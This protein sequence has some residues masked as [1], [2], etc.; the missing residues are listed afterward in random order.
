M[1]RIYA[2][3]IRRLATVVAI[4]FGGALFGFA[5]AQSSP[6][7]KPRTPEAAAIKKILEQRFDG[8][9]IGNISKTPYFGLYEVQF[10]D[11]LVYTDAKVTYI[12]VGSIYDAATKKNLTEAKQREYSRISFDSLPLDLAFKRVKGNGA[13]KLAIFSDPDCPYCA[14]LEQELKGIDNVTIYTFL[15]PIDQLHPDAGRKAKVI[16]CSLDPVKAWDQFFDS[17]VLPKN[18]GDCDNPVA[19]TRELGQKLRV[20]ATPTLV[21]ADGTIIPG[22]LPVPQLEAEIVQGEAEAKRLATKK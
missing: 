12:V 5:F 14:R 10:D 21:F 22:A 4:A 18:N 3:A 17:R 9:T 13:R 6:N 8:V 16:W 19:A 15:Y 2:P 11:Q 1:T 20:T 7:D